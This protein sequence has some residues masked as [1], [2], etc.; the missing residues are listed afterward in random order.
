MANSQLINNTYKIS[1]KVIN[2][3]RSILTAHPTGDGVRRAKFII[4]NRDLTYQSLKR[5]KH[6]LENSVDKIQYA[7]AGGDLMLA[8]IN[9]ILG[10]E[11][12]G[13]NIS[14][15]TGSEAKINVNTATHAQ[16]NPRI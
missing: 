8:E 7:L 1:D 11:R 9:A 13:V 14:Q 12:N 10:A 16:Q 15:N 5:I 2:Y 4:N 3:I 6:D